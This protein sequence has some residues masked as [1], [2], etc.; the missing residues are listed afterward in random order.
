MPRVLKALI[1]DDS[2]FMRQRIRQSLDVLGVQTHAEAEDVPSGMAAFRSGQLDLVIMDMVMPGGSGLDLL[3]FIST[4]RTDA[5]VIVLTSLSQD[6]LDQEFSRLGARAIITKPFSDE[7]MKTAL[8]SIYPDQSFDAPIV[9]ATVEP[10]VSASVRQL[11]A[12]EDFFRGVPDRSAIDMS[13]WCKAAWDLD[14][15]TYRTTSKQSFD[16]FLQRLLTT[17]VVEVKITLEQAV[18]IVGLALVPLSSVENVAAAVSGKERETLAIP[19]INAL[20]TEWANVI[21]ASVVNLFANKMK[22]ILL[23][24]SPKVL[25]LNAEEMLAQ[26]PKD[27]GETPDRVLAVLS[28]YSCEPLATSC[29]TLFFLRPDCLPGT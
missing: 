22:T 28:Q 11:A 24:S 9:A 16:L 2:A 21:V 27:L 7:D 25:Q 23:S 5:N 3:K 1:V 17:K 12:L 20:L 6:R 26:I 15:V 18:K 29:E 8:R 10:T 13:R 4:A 19:E 14:S